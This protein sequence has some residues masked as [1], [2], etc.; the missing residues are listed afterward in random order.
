MSWGF[1]WLLN[2][3]NSFTQIL[4]DC[5]VW[6]IDG[7]V[8]AFKYTIWFVLEGIYTVI[9][10]LISAVDVSALITQAS[11]S[12]GLLPGAL[13]YLLLL[14][15]VPQGIAIIGSAYLIRMGLNLI[16]GAITRI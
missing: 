2:F 6:C 7:V 16:P 11:V 5:C 13:G 12:W 1:S 10:G 14:V 9:I 3:V 4:H 8:Y 15:G